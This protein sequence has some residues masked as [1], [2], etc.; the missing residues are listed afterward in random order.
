MMS[1]AQVPLP[2]PASLAMLHA[3]AN[4]LLSIFPSAL[5]RFSVIESPLSAVV[6]LAL[7]TRHEQRPWLRT[8]KPKWEVDN[9]ESAQTT[10]KEIGHYHHGHQDDQYQDQ[11]SERA[12]AY[13]QK[14]SK[15]YLPAPSHA[16]RALFRQNTAVPAVR[17]LHPSN[18]SVLHRIHRDLRWEKQDC[19]VS[20]QIALRRVPKGRSTTFALES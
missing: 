17:T 11:T 2:V 14:L 4:P 10:C 15:S 12:L 9:K 8:D 3:R 16:W 20:C 18:S 13:R 5:P 1:V 19:V 7:N 6:T